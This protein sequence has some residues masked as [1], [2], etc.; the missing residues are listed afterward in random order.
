M[1]LFANDFFY[2]FISMFFLI[3]RSF[4]HL[5]IMMLHNNESTFVIMSKMCGV[6]IFNFF[7]PIDCRC[8]IWLSIKFK[9]MVTARLNFSAS[10]VCLGVLDINFNLTHWS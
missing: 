7:S 10:T 9:E 4:L 8:M 6:A 1:K 5:A 2:L 3:A